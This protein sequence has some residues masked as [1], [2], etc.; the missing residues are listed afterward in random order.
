MKD[1]RIIRTRILAILAIIAFLIIECFVLS[2]AKFSYDHQQ[3]KYIAEEMSIQLSFISSSLQSGDKAEYTK[4]LTAFRLA[5][6][7]FSK[8]HYV[9]SRAADLLSKLKHYSGELLEN[10]ELTAQMM[11]LRVAIATISS[12]SVAAQTDDIDA[13]KVYDI[14]QNYTNFRDGLGVITAPELTDL[15]QSLTITSND[16]IQVLEKSAVCVS[17]CP[18]GALSEKQKAVED[19]VI[20][21]KEELEKLSLTVSDKFNPNQLILDL[22]NYS[23]L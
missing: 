4:A 6:D 12:V 8:N 7:D 11:E 10:S 16:M 21:H 17:I 1:K 20:R 15:V 5:L 14:I 19:T 18:D 23:K 9:T 22:N 3:S 13:I 2:F